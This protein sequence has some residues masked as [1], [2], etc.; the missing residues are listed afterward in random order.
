M[1]LS[2]GCADLSES[3]GAALTNAEGASD[4]AP[5]GES[6]LGEPLVTAEDGLFTVWAFGGHIM[7]NPR[8]RFLYFFMRDLPVAQLENEAIEGWAEVTQDSLRVGFYVARN[9]IIIEHTDGPLGTLAGPGMSFEHIA[10]IGIIEMKSHPFNFQDR[11]WE[12]DHE[13]LYFDFEEESA[14]AFAQML[15]QALRLVDDYINR[16]S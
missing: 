8:E 14:E 7:Y 2:V 9:D 12:T 1:L 11:G 10:G 15:R 16:T 5:E 13:P 3:N 4:P 6:I